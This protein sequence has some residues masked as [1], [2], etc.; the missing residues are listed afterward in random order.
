MLSP[1]EFPLHGNL[2][3]GL[4]AAPQTQAKR[5]L[6][7]HP[8]LQSKGSGQHHGPAAAAAP[9]NLLEMETLGPHP[10]LMKSESEPSVPAQPLP[11]IHQLCRALLQPPSTTLLSTGK[12][13]DPSTRAH[14]GPAPN[15]TQPRPSNSLPCQPWAHSRSCSGFSLVC[16]EGRRCLHAHTPG[17]RQR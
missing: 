16:S 3:R 15:L 1:S 10:R 9:G 14:V 6:T 11:E 13:S 17:P 4:T 8:E 2:S 5:T 7:L 12:G